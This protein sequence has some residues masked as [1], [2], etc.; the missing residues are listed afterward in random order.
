MTNEELMTAFKIRS[1][2]FS[3]V[4]RLLNEINQILFRAQRLRG[5]GHLV[6]CATSAFAMIFSICSWNYSNEDDV[7]L[8]GRFSSEKHWETRANNA[9][10]KDWQTSIVSLR[11]A[12]SN[13]SRI[14]SEKPLRFYSISLQQTQSM[15]V[16]AFSQKIFF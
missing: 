7:K 8:Q 6:L 9:N 1:E 12:S 4:Q 5:E 3:E 16:F 10:L 15:K 11:A 14:L 2:N 13:N